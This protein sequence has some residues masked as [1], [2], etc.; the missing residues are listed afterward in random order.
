MTTCILF[1]LFI[2]IEFIVIEHCACVAIPL[3]LLRLCVYIMVKH[4]HLVKVPPMAGL[5]GNRSAH[6]L[7]DDVDR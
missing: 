3:L 6:L 4:F 5:S 2:S 1:L 7:N